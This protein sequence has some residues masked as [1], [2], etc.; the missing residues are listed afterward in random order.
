[1]KLRTLSCGS[2]AA[3]TGLG[4]AAVAWVP[5]V[6]DA[7]KGAF[8]GGRKAVTEVGQAAAKEASTYRRMVSEAQQMYP[9]KAG[10][11]EYHHISPQ[12]LGGPKNGPK[13]PLDGA[14][15]QQITNEFRNQ[16]RYG[17]PKPN[18]QELQKIMQDTNNILC[19]LT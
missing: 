9:K 19:H 8:K 17:N 1:M 5:G 13:V 16:W 11:T 3:W 7:A 15:H 12:Y 14:Y 6:G 10:K 18:S 4:G 2:G